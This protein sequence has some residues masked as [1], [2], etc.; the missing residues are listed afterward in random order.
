MAILDALQWVGES[1]DKPGAAV[2][3]L[4]AGRPGQLANLIPFSDTLGLTDPKERT[5]GRDLLQK[6]GMLGENT[7][8]LD[9]G[10]VAGFGVDVLSGFGGDYGVLKGAG[11]LGRMAGRY[12]DEA[13]KSP[14][15][16]V[17]G[18]ALGDFSQYGKQAR[19]V[20][21]DEAMSLY[22]PWADSLSPEEAEAIRLFTSGPQNAVSSTLRGISPNK[23]LG[24]IPN[25]GVS[26]APT[27]NSTER[28]FNE[29]IPYADS[30]IAKGEGILPDT[31]TYRLSQQLGGMNAG[32]ARSKIGEILTDPSY[33]STT[34][35]P[36][37]RFYGTSTGQPGDMLLDILYPKGTPGA[38]PNAGGLSKYPGEL[39]L[40]TPRDLPLKVLDVKDIPVAKV[41]YSTFRLTPEG[42]PVPNAGSNAGSRVLFDEAKLDSLARRPHDPVFPAGTFESPKVEDF[43]VPGWEKVIAQAEKENIANVL[44]EA[45]PGGLPN[46]SQLATRRLLPEESAEVIKQLVPA[47]RS[48]VD[49]VQGFDRLVERVLTGGRNPAFLNEQIAKASGLRP[50][51]LDDLLKSSVPKDSAIP[52]MLNLL[53]KAGVP[54][55]VGG[56]LP[57]LLQEMFAEAA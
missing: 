37:G 51:Q 27:I 2:R 34:I 6:W 29:M 22:R 31:V 17:F 26:S 57:S 44:L 41:G 14:T 39:E 8:G 45:L 56:A 53:K 19:Q 12:A 20:S 32:N 3:G 18:G 50:N 38:F 42:L 36:Y 25:L 35:T 43:L 40:I 23:P 49:D 55:A 15:L 46:L 48:Q 24:E 21:P 52:A 7:P 11:A 10:D 47:I 54:L 30:A 9:M 16:G 13:V 28:I 33:Q 5:Y 4:L 1:L